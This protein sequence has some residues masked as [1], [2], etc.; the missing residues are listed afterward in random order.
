MRTRRRLLAAATA[1]AVLVPAAAE[2]HKGPGHGHGHG[3]GSL[4]STVALPA[5][6]QPEGIEARGKTFF[7][8][9]RA[10]GQIVVGSVKGG[11]TREL[12][13]AQ[14]DAPS[15]LGLRLDHRGRLFVSG[16]RTGTVSVYEARTGRLLYRAKPASDPAFV[17][18]VALLR[19]KAVFTDSAQQRLVVAPIGRRGALGE[20]RTVPITGSLAYDADPA[21]IEA[22]GIVASRDGRSVIVVNS[23]TGELHRVDPET[24]VST[25]IPVAGG[26]L[27]NGDGLLRAGKTLFAVQ[28][29]LNR[30]AVLRLAKDESSATVRR[31]ITDPQFDVPTTLAVA[32]GRLFTVNARFTTPPAADTAYDVVRVDGK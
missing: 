1:A 5:G 29:R 14:A 11:P 6:L 8:G 24:G 21:T 30:I 26:P 20:A 7:A 12:V 31:T 19:D 17:N 28:N 9:S 2:A 16:G 22:N 27:A 4:P 32:K 10:T 25:L 23:R 13:P 3:G 15:A 18:D